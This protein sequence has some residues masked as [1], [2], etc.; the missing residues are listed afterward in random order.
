MFPLPLAGGVRGGLFLF[1]GSGSAPLFPQLLVAPA[2]P[3]VR[4]QPVVQSGLWRSP[5][6]PCGGSGGL[7]GGVL[8]CLALL[9]A[10]LLP[11]ES[12][13]QDLDQPGIVD[14]VQILAG[15]SV[16]ALAEVEQLG[17][18]LG[19]PVADVPGQFRNALLKAP[20]S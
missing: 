4:A 12:C 16:M 5:S 2:Q 7:G 20:G 18:G 19:R 10:M 6:H 3:L 9:V 11:L 8:L 15:E 17:C 14:P 1:A 13:V